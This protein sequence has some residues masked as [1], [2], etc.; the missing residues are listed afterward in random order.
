MPDRPRR[1][2]WWEIL[3]RVLYAIAA[4]TGALATLVT[5]VNGLELF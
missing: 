3:V 4:L 1:P 2:R 5:A